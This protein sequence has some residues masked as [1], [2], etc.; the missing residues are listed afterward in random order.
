[1]ESSSFVPEFIANPTVVEN[2]KCP[3]PIFKIIP[4]I[5]KQDDSVGVFSKIPKRVTF[6]EDL[7]IYIHCNIENFGTDALKKIY[8][9][10]I[11]DEQGLVK[12]EH[13][14]VG[15]L[16][17]VEILNIPEF[18]K[19]VV[20]LVLSR[21]HGEFIWLDS[22]FKISK[23]EI[24]VVTGL[25]STSSRPNKIKNIPNKGVMDL[26][27]ATSDNRSLRVNDITDANVRYVSM[28]LGYR[29]TH[30]NRLNYVSRLCIH[31]AYEMVKNNAWIDICEWL[32]DELI[33]NLK[34]IKGYK[35]GTFY[36]ATYL[37][38]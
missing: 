29:V 25:P 1:M 10:V 16:G 14:I 8:S 24:K 20:C 6:A 27:R 2:I 31:S 12:P 21:V 13:K 15:D 17:F 4:E 9:D 37:C 34:K 26:T 11:I 28:V 3:R 18:L 30:G 22:I 5:S 32:K 19:E 7:R 38:V 36:L 35:K 33:D 23:E